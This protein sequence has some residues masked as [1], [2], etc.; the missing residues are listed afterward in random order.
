[1]RP[2]SKCATC[3]LELGEFVETHCPRCGRSLAP[4]PPVTVGV[5]LLD[6]AMGI[7]AVLF[8]MGCI[9]GLPLYMN[10]SARAEL[11]AGQPYHATAF[12]VTYVQ[13]SVTPHPYRVFAYATGMVEGK[14]ETMDLI[15]YLGTLPGMQTRLPVNQGE[16]MAI[17]PEGTVIPVYLFPNLAGANRIQM[18]M[19]R[20]PAEHYR[21]LTAWT[22]N[23]AFPVVALFGII[24]GLLGLLRF[25]IFRAGQR[26]LAA[27]AN[28][29]LA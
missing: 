15:P 4:K 24:A 7:F 17:V 12:R 3:G 8:V 13:Y 16:L 20:P 25:A 19:M 26:R 27:M 11:Y 21:W 6:L 1:M 5:W 29:A 23:K 10:S 18:S 2:P 22:S 14:K 28:G 9:F